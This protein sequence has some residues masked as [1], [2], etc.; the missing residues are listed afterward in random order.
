MF[1]PLRVTR[2]RGDQGD[3]VRGGRAD[4][5]LVEV[6][7]QSETIGVL[8]QERN[9]VAV[10]MADHHLALLLALQ[11]RVGGRRDIAELKMVAPAPDASVP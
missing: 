7:E 3:R 9:R 6:V 1:H 10:D 11:G 5:G 8:P 2:L 4:R